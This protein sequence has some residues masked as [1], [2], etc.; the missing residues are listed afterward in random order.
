MIHVLHFMFFDNV[1]FPTTPFY[2]RSYRS[3]IINTFVLIFLLVKFIF[4]NLY[5]LSENV[6]TKG[7]NI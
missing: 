2:L 4:L 5:F 6:L 3:N 7:Q 1:S